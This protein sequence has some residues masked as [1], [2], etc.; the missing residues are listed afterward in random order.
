M[1][2]DSRA[3][4]PGVA[5]EAPRS[6]QEANEVFKNGGERSNFTASQDRERERDGGR[7]GGM[8]GVK[9]E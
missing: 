3:R 4:P 1:K 6:A 2:H 8:R 9:D 5:V 7:E